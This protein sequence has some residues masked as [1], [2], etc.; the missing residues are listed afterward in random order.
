MDSLLGRL[1]TQFNVGA[2]RLAAAT[3]LDIL[4]RCKPVRDAMSELLVGLGARSSG[5]LSYR[6]PLEDS[7]AEPGEI[8]VVD[9]GAE[10][11]A[12]A[13]LFGSGPPPN[14]V[15][16][17]LRVRLAAGGLALFV[18]PTR[19]RDALWDFLRERWG[20][21]LPNDGIR[22]F[23]NWGRAARLTS[24]RWLA[25]ATWP[26]VLNAL[27]L[28]AFRAAIPSTVA[29]LHQLRGLV[30]RMDDSGFS[31]FATAELL[32]PGGRTVMQLCDL[33]DQL[34][35]RFRQSE[36]P[37]S[38]VGGRYFAAPFEWNRA[39]VRV[40]Y[41]PQDWGR[42]G[43]PLMLEIVRPRHPGGLPLALLLAPATAMAEGA[44]HARGEDVW[45]ALNIRTRSSQTEVLDDLIFQVE[46]ALR[47]LADAA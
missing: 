19:R 46:A 41:S 43:H 5:A 39:T 35:Y 33:A 6:E 8:S 38:W 20:E 26:S 29:D 3:L 30:D 16:K 27:E 28:A 32:P 1:A 47:R 37:G 9:P 2:E 45:L 31:P 14:Q 42:T 10:R 4:Q 34:G 22:E 25:L 15:G 21:H 13:L 11:A 18:A 7:D 36:Q 24:G 12:I 40:C 23:G 44:I 17:L